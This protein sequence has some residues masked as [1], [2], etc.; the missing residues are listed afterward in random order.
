[1]ARATLGLPSIGWAPLAVAAGLVTLTTAHGLGV[2]EILLSFTEARETLNLLSEWRKPELLSPV[3]LPYVLGLVIVVIGAY[4]RL[5][6]PKHLWLLVP[7]LALALTATRAV[8]PAWMA[9]LPLLG[10]SL[11]GLSTGD[12]P[13]FGAAAIGVF[14]VAIFVIPLLVRSD[15]Q[16]DDTRFPIDSATK[17]TSDHVFH[18]DR[19]G[20]Y[21]IYAYGPERLVYLDDRAEL[22]LDRMAEFVQ[23]REGSTPWQP[24]FERDGIEEALL[25]ADEE[26][27]DDLR[28]SCWSETFVDD[29][30]VGLTK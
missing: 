1:M 17:L 22:Y 18:D 3:F 15:A 30:F 8:P 13:R 23:V 2:V 11:R 27:A 29:R 9:M 14:A 28:R 26:L 20:G 21:L 24:V 5:I 6:E 16:L 10:V 19:T 4:R 7:F 25:L 12:A